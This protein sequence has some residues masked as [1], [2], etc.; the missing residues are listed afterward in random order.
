MTSASRAGVLAA[1]WTADLLQGIQLPGGID[2]SQIDVRISGA[3]V[4]A[5]AGLGLLAALVFGALPALY[6]A[7]GDVVGG[8]KEQAA[9]RRGSRQRL[10]GALVSAQ[11]AL[12]LVLLVGASLF[13]RTLQTTLSGDLGFNPGGVAYAATNLSLERYEYSS[14][15][16]SPDRRKN[17]RQQ[18]HSNPRPAT[19]TTISTAQS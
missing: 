7:R 1:M 9:A 18:S 11:V 4:A 10:R 14:S 15:A 17:V 8:L 2:M 3:A 6:S 19:P 12:S 13:A 5:T 16:K